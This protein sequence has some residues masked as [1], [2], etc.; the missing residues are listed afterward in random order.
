MEFIIRDTF[1]FDETPPTSVSAAEVAALKTKLNSAEFKIFLKEKLKDY[2]D[3][4]VIG[5][6]RVFLPHRGKKPTEKRPKTFAVGV[7]KVNDETK[8]K[9]V[10]FHPYSYTEFPWFF[11]KDFYQNNLG[12]S[13]RFFHDGVIAGGAIA[14]LVNEYLFNV[15][16]VI[17]DVDYFYYANFRFKNTKELEENLYAS[18]GK[19]ESPFAI[20]KAQKEDKVN[21][22]KVT[23]VYGRKDPWDGLL[24]TFD[25]NCTMIW[26][27]PLTLEVSFTNEF[28]DFIN[29]RKITHL[30]EFCLSNIIRAKRKAAELSATYYFKDE[31]RKLF[32]EDLRSY[33]SF[34]GLSLFNFLINSGHIPI[35]EDFAFGYLRALNFIAE[36]DL[37]ALAKDPGFLMPYFSFKS[38]SLKYEGGFPLLDFYIKYQKS[39]RVDKEQFLNPNSFKGL[40]QKFQPNY[41]VQEVSA[42]YYD[43]FLSLLGAYREMEREF[44][45]QSMTEWEKTKFNKLLSV[46]FEETKFI[47]LVKKIKNHH[48]LLNCFFILLVHDWSFGEAD[49]IL[50][51]VL[52]L[53]AEGIGIFENLIKHFQN[54]PSFNYR[55]GPETIK[56]VLNTTKGNDF[57]QLFL[58][59]VKKIQNH[60][61]KYDFLRIKEDLGSFKKYIRELTTASELTDESTTMRH[62]VQGYTEQVRNY[63][64]RIFHLEIHGQKTTLETSAGLNG[65]F[66]VKQH[67]G[68]ANSRPSSVSILLA[69]LLVNY[70]NFKAGHL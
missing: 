44:P 65:N 63:E 14:A 37:T 1:T 40:F 27:H 45:N 28:V 17:N 69:N 33:S 53:G 62:C 64:S 39:A 26:V 42:K 21:L 22:I 23:N 47:S 35:Q 29:T 15:P 19:E 24:E 18:F 41:P 60:N 16:A 32:L 11:P 36:K 34:Q 55:L 51:R 13:N 67:T 56:I 43:R 61:A 5:Q 12:R 6:E 30:E 4:P 54:T 58:S 50:R 70:L 25:L 59:L 7:E 2:L 46:S 20:V 31:L 8:I 9:K 48:S 66:K 10:S 52:N 49:T 38:K 3:H 68:F 57:Y